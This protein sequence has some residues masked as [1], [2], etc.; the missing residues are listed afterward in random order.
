MSF[1]IEFQ[2]NVFDNV[3][4]KVCIHSIHCDVKWMKTMSNVYFQSCQLMF[5]GL[6][7]TTSPFS[8]IHNLVHYPCAHCEASYQTWSHYTVIIFVT[9]WGHP[10]KRWLDQVNLHDY[11]EDSTCTPS[12]EKLASHRGSISSPYTDCYNIIACQC[13]YTPISVWLLLQFSHTSIL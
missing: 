4:H 7:L 3:R 12:L 1:E 13:E 10:S 11:N 6:I 9:C 5:R 2:S 8:S